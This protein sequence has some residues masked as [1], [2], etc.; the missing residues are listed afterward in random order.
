MTRGTPAGT[1]ATS[2]PYCGR[3]LQVCPSCRGS[4]D[5]GRLCQQF[6]FGTIYP[7]CRR[8]WTWA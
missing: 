6:M 8:Q 4:Y 5:T 3:R 1:Q 7:T 2:F